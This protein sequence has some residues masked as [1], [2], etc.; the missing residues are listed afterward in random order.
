MG[1]KTMASSMFCY[2]EWTGRGCLKRD[3]YSNAA[4][5]KPMCVYRFELLFRSPCLHSVWAVVCF[6]H[7]PL[8]RCPNGYVCEMDN[9]HLQYGI[10]S[11]NGLNEWALGM[12][13]HDIKGSM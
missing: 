6:P 5:R 7:C 10:A 2:A 12:G 8:P 3:V 13:N 11:N 4:E 9:G 1:Q